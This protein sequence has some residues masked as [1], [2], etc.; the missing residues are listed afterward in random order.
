MS[1]VFKVLI[2]SGSSGGHLF[3]AEA[4]LD[5][6]AEKKG[7]ESLLVLPRKNILV[8]SDASGFKTEYV[9]V[10]SIGLEPT[11]KNL[12]AF[13]H[14]FKGAFESAKILNRFKPDV[15]AGFGSIV[16]VPMVLLARSK[17]IKILIH[18]QNVLPGRATRFLSGWADSIAVSFGE[19][20]KYLKRP[21]A[22][23]VFT[24]NPLRKG[25]SVIGREEALK[26][27]GL[28]KDKFTILVCGGS[29]ASSR[30]NSAFLRD[31]PG[32]VRP[33]AIQVIHLSGG[34]ELEEVKKR[35]KEMGVEARCFGFLDKMQYAYSCSDLAVSRSG[36]TT[37]AELAFFK[38]PAVLLPYPYAYRH[39]YLNAGVLEKAGCALVIDDAGLDKGALKKELAR[40]LGSRD[41]VLRMRDSFASLAQSDH[42]ELLR[43]ALL[44]LINYTGAS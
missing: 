34:K 3:P 21:G 32:I 23:V 9:S 13:F 17:G 42:G 19:T 29:Q 14:F 33:S 26:F 27:F 43:E 10:S 8:A 12:K 40:L 5:A 20:E 11:F 4:L 41:E 2:V 30:I 35:Y 39:Q 6:L 24:G 18:E 25:L 16:S 31:L 28:S 38:L 1:Q 22:R 15:V 44:S 36:A 37:I 7:I